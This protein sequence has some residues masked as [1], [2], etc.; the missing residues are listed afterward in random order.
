MRGERKKSLFEVD[1]EAET[2]ELVEE[3]VERLGDARGGHSV[4]FN[5]SLVSFATAVNIVTL[6]GQDFL[7]D[8]RC[9]ESFERPNLHFTETLATELSFTTK[10]LLSDKRVRANRAGVHFVF[11]HVTEF[12]HVDDAHSSG[13]VETLTGAAVVEVSFTVAGE[14]GFVGP[15]VKVIK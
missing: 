15:F 11:D 10:G 7:K 13:L 9:A 3:Y 2:A 14:T 6:D 12:E 8:V 1:A 5:D 4:A